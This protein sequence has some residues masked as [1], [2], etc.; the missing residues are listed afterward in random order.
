MRAPVGVT[1]VT[2]IESSGHRRAMA[3]TSGAAAAASPT[4]TAWI[5]QRGALGSPGSKRPSLSPSPRR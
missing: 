4:E 5:Q 1:V 2:T 3:S